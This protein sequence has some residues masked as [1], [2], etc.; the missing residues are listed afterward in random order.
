MDASNNVCADTHAN[1]T[2]NTTSTDDTASPNSR[3]KHAEPANSQ[4]PIP[5]TMLQDGQELQVKRELSMKGEHD[6]PVHEDYACAARDKGQ[7][8]SK[9]KRR[10]DVRSIK[11]EPGLCSSLDVGKRKS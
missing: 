7:V 6:L 8:S 2:T 11:V 9:N 5:P 10:I 4:L 1:E 3:A